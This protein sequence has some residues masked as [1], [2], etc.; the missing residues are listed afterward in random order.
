MKSKITILVMIMFLI[1]CLSAQYTGEG[2]FEKLQHNAAVETGYYVIGSAQLVATTNSIGIHALKSE[3]GGSGNATWTYSELISDNIE[4]TVIENPGTGLVHFIEK[5]NETGNY[6][7][8]R[9]T[10]QFFLNYVS[11][12]TTGVSYLA[13]IGND[14]Q[15]S[16]TGN[17]TAATAPFLIQSVSGGT[18]RQLRYRPDLEPGRFNA[19]ASGQSQSRPTMLF[20]LTSEVIPVPVITNV[21]PITTPPVVNQPLTI[22]ATVTYTG[23]EN[24]VVHFS[25]TLNGEDHNLAMQAT[26]NVYSATL[27]A[28]IMTVGA[29]IE[30]RVVAN[31]GA[32]NPV[33]S[34][35]QRFFV[36]TTPM[37]T[38]RENN[39][40]G[41]PK[42]EGYLVQITGV[43]I[44]SP[45]VISNAHTDFMM[46]D[47]TAG[48][49]VYSSTQGVTFP[50][51]TQ[52]N[53]Y[54]VIGTLSRFNGRTQ[55]APTNITSHG[56]GVLPEPFLNTIAYFTTYATAERYES[57][58]ITVKNVRIHD[59]SLP[60]PTSGT[61]TQTV[62]LTDG[63]AQID[64]RVLPPLFGE[65][66]DFPADIVAIL[67]QW[68]NSAP[69]TEGYQIFIRNFNDVYPTEVLPVTITSFSVSAISNS[70]AKV[71]WTT[72]SEVNMNRYKILR[73][74]TNAFA[75]AVEVYAVASNNL[76]LS[77][78]YE[79]IDNEVKSGEEYFYWL[80]I[81]ENNGAVDN[82]GPLSVVIPSN[83]EPPV[84]DGFT[85][86]SNVYPNPV[87]NTDVAN[88][89]VSVRANETAS[90]KIFNLRG[91]LVREFDNISG[92]DVT[93]IWDGRDLYNREASAGVYFYQFTSPSY[94]SVNRLVIVK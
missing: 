44:N 38:L 39:A 74:T 3:L 81:I 57:S 50:E 72:E 83:N 32:P 2:V 28:T 59:S 7:I 35:P 48:M 31:Y 46:Q 93:L 15:W 70:A 25:Y 41:L 73:N 8:Q 60:W 11:A 34:P 29:A 78:T 91:Q 49:S 13:A 10:D 63:T 24:L 51:V 65:A 47:E 56:I 12:G 27:P 45:S 85:L 68:D 75:A 22:S 80:Q 64:L 76:P 26:G 88:F 37:L 66:P 36:G 61:G 86:I 62:V 30:L 89:N 67:S 18:N 9:V 23:V 54:T 5:N 21:T 87:R 58:L 1:T 42:F 69:H 43:A 20:K 94:F 14:T 55:I 79:F 90:L 16:I 40:N 19:V 82:R 6:T 84:D 33:L 53:S 52:G 77:Q 17:E 71:Q 92:N 4:T